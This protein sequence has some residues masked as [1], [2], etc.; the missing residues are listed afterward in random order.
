MMRTSF[1][2]L[3]ACF[4]AS[5]VCANDLSISVSPDVIDPAAGQAAIFSFVP[6]NDGQALVRILGPDWREVVSIEREGL[7]KGQSAQIS[8]DGRDLSGDFV[9]N[10][11]YFPVLEFYDTRGEATIVDPSLEF[12]VGPVLVQNVAYD[13]AR[14]GVGFT[15]EIPARVTLYAGLDGG[16]PLMN[17]LLS[18]APYPPGD[19]FVPWDG[20]DKS[21][22]V[23]IVDR[24]DFR[25]FASADTAWAPGVIVRGTS[26][27]PYPL[28]TRALGDSAPIKAIP[29]IEAIG[30]LRADLP[31]P[32]DVSPEPAF[33]LTLG[34][35]APMDGGLPV[36][37]GEVPLVVSL[38]PKVRVPVLARRFEIVLFSNFEFQ[39]EVEEGR[40]PATVIWDTTDIAPGEY[41]LTVNVATLPGQ[42]SA[43]SI[44]VKLV[45]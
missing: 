25:I 19:H 18:D 37:S 8:W 27:E 2:Q 14:K 3:A 43:A 39:T 15:L 40:S 11:A 17:T 26:Q 13:E 5:S 45:E 1:A 23:R 22:I 44:R 10:E 33:D 31:R 16:G 12:K 20:M 38:D 21:G 34:I 42:L 9:A 29:E 24:G 7:T 32:Q 6:P 35:D 4:V 41:V 28:Y 30:G 36:V